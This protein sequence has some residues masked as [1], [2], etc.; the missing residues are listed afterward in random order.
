MKT[1][2]I[3][4]AFTT[5]PVMTAKG[6]AVACD[7]EYPPECNHEKISILYSDWWHDQDTV[8]ARNDG[9]AYAVGVVSDDD[10]PAF[11]VS[12]DITEIPEAEALSVGNTLRPQVEY[13]TDV[14]G[15]AAIVKKLDT[16]GLSLA[17]RS[18]LNPDS[19]QPGIGKSPSF[20]TLYNVEKTK[21][22]A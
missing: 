20:A 2:K 13:V 5:R 22:D 1:L 4:L 19:E 17:E 16:S 18:A 15:V 6:P 12:D 14:K 8:V 9:T 21:R 10:A 3:N 7:V 11:L